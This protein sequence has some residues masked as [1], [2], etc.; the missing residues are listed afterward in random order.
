M[1]RISSAVLVQRNGLGSL[2]HLLIQVRTSRSSSTR[3]RWAE[4]RSFAVSQFGKPAL[5]EV[6][7]GGRGG[8]EVQ[9]EARVAQQPFFHLRGLV[10]AVVIA[11]E[12]QVQ[13]GWHGVVN[14]F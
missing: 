5:D 8:G 14:R 12:V 2:F 13:A 1:S 6:E 4:R 7:P 9:L 11:D 10:G 3:L